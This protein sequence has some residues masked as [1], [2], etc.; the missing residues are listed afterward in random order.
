MPVNVN[1]AGGYIPTG[2]I[3]D[4]FSGE[5][6]GDFNVLPHFLNFTIFYCQIAVKRLFILSIYDPAV[7]DYVVHPELSF[8]NFPDKL[9]N[10]I[11][12]RMLTLPE[13][14]PPRSRHLP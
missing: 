11:I 9:T 14:H 8:L 1:K 5:V 3:Q 13:A 6:R 12:L 10:T 2:R 4:T 7:F